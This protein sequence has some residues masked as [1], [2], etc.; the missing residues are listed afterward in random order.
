MNNEKAKNAKQGGE[1]LRIRKPHCAKLVRKIH[2]VA[3]GKGSLS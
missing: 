2:E 3:R 1:M